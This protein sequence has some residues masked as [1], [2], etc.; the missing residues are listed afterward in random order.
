MITIC[1]AIQCPVLVISSN[2]DP[3]QKK[4]KKNK[5]KQGNLEVG[6]NIIYSPQS[7]KIFMEGVDRKYYKY[8]WWFTFD[9]YRKQNYTET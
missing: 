8:I 4:T 3:T 9:V 7:V 2:S 5:K 6:S 1:L